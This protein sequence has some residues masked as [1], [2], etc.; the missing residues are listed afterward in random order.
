MEPRSCEAGPKGGRA[1]ILLPVVEAQ[2]P[3]WCRSSGENTKGAFV[4]TLPDLDPRHRPRSGQHRPLRI[5]SE[6][7]ARENVCVVGMDCKMG[8][9]GLVSVVA[10]FAH[11]RLRLRRSENLHRLTCCKGPRDLKIGL[12]KLRQYL[13]RDPAVGPSELRPASRPRS[14]A[15]AG[16][17]TNSRTPSAREALRVVMTPLRHSRQP[18]NGMWQ[19]SPEVANGLKPEQ[20]ASATHPVRRPAMPKRRSP[21]LRQNCLRRRIGQDCRSPAPAS[22]RWAATHLRQR[23][24]MPRRWSPRGSPV[25]GNRSGSPRPRQYGRPQIGAVGRRSGDTRPP[26]ASAQTREAILMSSR[27]LAARDAFDPDFSWL[28][29]SVVHR[30]SGRGRNT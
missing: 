4:E 24:T 25:L 1:H 3:R 12:R 20:L 10:G 21:C 6:W 9:D 15:C 5:G 19:A 2:D 16:P 29:A 14:E 23:P 30:S 8:S 7:S 27:H 26:G 28:T 18:Q 13:R 22:T 17:T 11:V